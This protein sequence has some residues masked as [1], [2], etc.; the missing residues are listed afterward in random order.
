LEGGKDRKVTDEAMNWYN[1]GEMS[2]SVTGK[3]MLVI[4]SVAVALRAVVFLVTSMRLGLSVSQYAN[5]YDGRSY[6]IVARAMAGEKV[7]SDEYDWRV[8]PGFPALIAAAHQSGLSF[9]ASGLAIVWMSA[10]IAAAMAGRLFADERIGWATAMLIPH[11]LMNS[12]MCMSE[13]PLLAL[14]LTGLVAAREWGG[15]IG[16]AVVGAAGLVRPMACFAAIGGVAR[17]IW[18]ATIAGSHRPSWITLVGFILGGAACFGLGLVALSFLHVDPLTTARVQLTHPKAYGG[19]LFTWPLHS[20]IVIPRQ[21]H[22]P[23]G[24]V[25]YMWVHVAVVLAG[26]LI[27]AK[28]VSRRGTDERNALAAPWLIGNTAFILCL[29]TLWGFTCFHRFT[30]AAEPALFWAIRGVLPRCKWGWIGVAVASTLIAA[31]SAGN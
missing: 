5:L 12:T 23:L 16:G 10:G 24:Q 26:S 14:S 7:Q 17:E 1:I 29:N 4:A 22:K 9:E 30:V 6:L 31:F 20:M 28:A 15:W 25:I 11:Y 2:G 13:A 19:H 18:H 27:L 3:K 8:F 21:L